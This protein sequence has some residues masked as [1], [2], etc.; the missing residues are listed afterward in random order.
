M[1]ALLLH[2]ILFAM[3]LHNLRIFIAVAEEL[4]FGRAAERL[5]LAQPPV[6]RAV[7]RL[8]RDLGIDLLVRSTRKVELTP[9]GRELL[10]HAR[11]ILATV[12]DAR[13]ATLEAADG[14]VG[15]VEISY[16]GLSTHV[17]VGTLAKA[18]RVHN[19]GITLNLHSQNFAL[20]AL[21]MVEQGT[22]DI[23]LGRWLEIP[24][25]IEAR[26]VATEHLVVAVSKD[27]PLAG[28]TEISISSLA[29]EPLI[30][31]HD[32]PGSVLGARIQ[33]VF[34]SAGL[35]PR[36]IQRTPDTW[37]AISLVAAG[38]GSSLTVSPVRE[39]SYNPNVVFLEIIEETDP[40]ELRI[41]WQSPST[42]P[43]LP[44]VL[45]VAEQEW[46]VNLTDNP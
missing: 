20:P 7:Q 1:S 14:R 12:D 11:T 6:S 25:G 5:Y 33:E 8:E 30:A 31:L 35:R 4:H 40:I 34:Q 16:A 36:I 32:H 23:C 9:A 29:D 3:E 38:V 42:N 39:N 22:V 13:Q 2:V 27:H 46:G 45:S 21:H 43:S 18:M 28:E 24:P 10:Q 26:T 15:K 19:P 37:T 44:K 41:V 17:L